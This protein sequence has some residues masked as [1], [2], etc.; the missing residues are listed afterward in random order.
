[1]LPA[2]GVGDGDGD[3]FFEDDGGTAT[4]AEAE[5]V[6][7]SERVLSCVLPR[8][9]AGGGDHRADVCARFTP[10]VYDPG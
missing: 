10:T 5:V 8:G 1:M 4:E 3:D 7:T 6:W 9:G 2:S